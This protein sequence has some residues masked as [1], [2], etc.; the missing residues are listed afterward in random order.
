MRTLAVEEARRASCALDVEDPAADIEYRAMELALAVEGIQP[1]D[2][3]KFTD[4]DRQK[5]TQAAMYLLGRPIEG[6]PWPLALNL[7]G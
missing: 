5:W 7:P 4:S 3:K 2:F 1:D 6:K